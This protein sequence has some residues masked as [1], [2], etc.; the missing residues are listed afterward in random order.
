MT[1]YQIRNYTTILIALIVLV[2]FIKNPFGN[3]EPSKDDLALFP[4]LSAGEID[5]LVV[6]GE[7]G[8]VELIRQSPDSWIIQ[9]DFPLPADT[10]LVNKALRTVEQ[11]SSAN[12]VARNPA[13]HGLFEVDSTGARVEVFAGGD[14][15]AASFILGK[16]AQSGGTFYRLTDADDVYQSDR[17][18][19][20][21]F[22]RRQESWRN[23]RIFQTEFSEFT[24]LQVE[25]GDS[26]IVF[27]ADPDGNWQLEQPEAF[28]VEK[29]EVETMLRRVARL[30]AHSVPDSAVAAE[31]SG[32]DAP[33]LRVQAERIDGTG[34]ELLVGKQNDDG[35]FYCKAG[36]QDWIYLVAKYIVDPF[37]KDPLEM[38]ATEPTAPEGVVPPDGG[39]GT[40]GSGVGRG[41]SGG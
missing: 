35:Y 28:P 39:D 4:K 7:N 40:E 22:D 19:K 32:L 11:F 16:S 2:L 41:P 17:P 20:N 9:R 27:A 23:R 6:T 10:S 36:D 13:K 33:S 30:Y 31:T 25:H 12:R 15:P 21:E 38:K 14:E 3:R 18:I 24:R 37:Y 29:A 26:T 8:R 1:G 34:L 5:R